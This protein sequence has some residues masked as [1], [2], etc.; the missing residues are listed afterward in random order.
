M[1]FDLVLVSGL[2]GRVVG[3][4][5]GLGLCRVVLVSGGCAFDF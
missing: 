4:G 5:L 3:A 1:V 2:L